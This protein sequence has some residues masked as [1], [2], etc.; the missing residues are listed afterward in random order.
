M[1]IFYFFSPKELEMDD[2]AEQCMH[3]QHRIERYVA[4]MRSKRAAPATTT[5]SARA[6][7]SLD[8]TKKPVVVAAAAGSAGPGTLN[9]HY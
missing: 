6:R 4:L 8:L 9:V 7:D 5:R 2:F 1:R 3:L